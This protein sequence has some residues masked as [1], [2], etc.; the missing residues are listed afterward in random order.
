MA[1]PSRSRTDILE[2]AVPLFARDGYNGVS[3]RRLAETAGLTPAALYHHFP[4]KEALYL[5]AVRHAFEGKARELAAPL[6]LDIPPRRRLRA[7]LRRF[8][9]VTAADP[10]FR[11][12]VHR[13][14]LEGDEARLRLLAERVF[15]GLFARIMAL[16][17]ELAPGFDPHLLAVSLVALVA[18]HYETAPLRAFLPGARPEHDDPAVVARHVGRLLLGGI[19][20]PDAPER[21]RTA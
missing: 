4:D 5:A 18:H 8:A 12:L 13:E 17:G 10:D 11:R 3:M 7:F 9:E 20:P 1:A 6:D 2:A 14:I 19:A 21:L 16:A 15:G